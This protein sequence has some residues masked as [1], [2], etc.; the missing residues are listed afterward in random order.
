VNDEESD[1]ALML[2]YAAGDA[3]A[4]ERLYARL[5]KPLYGF[6]LRGL[7]DRAQADEC[8]QDVWTRVIAARQ[9]YQPDAR[10][11]T[12]LFQIAHNRM[13]DVWR[14]Q[15]PD[16]SLEA[17][18]DAGIGWVD[19]RAERPED[20]AGQFQQQRRLQEALKALP[21][22]QRIAVQLRLQQELSLEE[23]AEVTGSGRETVKSR[24]RYAM[25]KLRQTLGA[26]S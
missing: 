2:A 25:D 18:Q 9:R 6:L 12:W 1:E 13:V 20:A 22:E 3:Q 24:L 26:G 15:R 10:F 14:R 21:T 4:F 5:R 17:L 11:S 8:F 16:T 7:Q 19:D 23:I